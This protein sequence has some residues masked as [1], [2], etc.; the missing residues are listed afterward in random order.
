MKFDWGFLSAHDPK[1]WLASPLM[2]MQLRLLAQSYQIMGGILEDMKIRIDIVQ[3]RKAMKV[4]IDNNV[5]LY[6]QFAIPI[7]YHHYQRPLVES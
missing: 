1:G 4:N 5:R 3:C 2:E 6:R 7:L